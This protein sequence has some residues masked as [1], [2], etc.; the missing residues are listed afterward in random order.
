MDWLLKKYPAQSRKEI[1][2]DHNEGQNETLSKMFVTRLPL[3]RIV[4]ADELVQCIPGLG[5]LCDPKPTPPQ[6]ND[7]A[8]NCVL[9][10]EVAFW[11]LEF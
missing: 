4:G 1:A 6:R 9:P 11:K 7:Y 3:R 2:L 5:I 10:Q 8:T